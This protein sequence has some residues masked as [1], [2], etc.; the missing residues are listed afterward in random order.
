MI[1]LTVYSHFLFQT[2]V[3]GKSLTWTEVFEKMFKAF[4]KEKCLDKGVTIGGKHAEEYMPQA[5]NFFKENL[6]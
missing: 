3:K 5:L 6:L 4:K 2:I 1:L